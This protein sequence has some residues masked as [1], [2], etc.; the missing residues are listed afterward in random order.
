MPAHIRPF[1]P[2]GVGLIRF[3]R[4][5]YWSFPRKLLR[6]SGTHQVLGSWAGEG[7]WAPSDAQTGKESHTVGPVE[8]NDEGLQFCGVSC[9]QKLKLRHLLLR[10]P[11]TSR[12]LRKKIPMS[13]S[14]GTRRSRLPR[15]SWSLRTIQRCSGKPEKSASDASFY[16]SLGTSPGKRSPPSLRFQMS[17]KKRPGRITIRCEPKKKPTCGRRC[18]SWRR[19]WSK[20][21]LI[22]IPLAHPRMT[23]SAKARATP[24]PKFT[25][26]KV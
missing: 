16:D 21:E 13:S 25:E 5:A 3:T 10:R 22:L 15:G 23:K 18:R 6:L 1:D 14:R 4:R 20:N 11:P 26:V 24:A 17:K 2:G 7:K 12:R 9:S 19:K 8:E